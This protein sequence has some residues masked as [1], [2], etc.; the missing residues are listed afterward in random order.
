VLK[1]GEKITL[2]VDN[3]SG[4]LDTVVK[5]YDSNGNLVASSD[6]SSPS[7]G[8][9]GSSRDYWYLF[10]IPASYDSYL[11]YTATQDGA[12]YVDIE[13]KAGSGTYDLQVSIDN[14][15][16]F[17]GEAVTIPTDF[18]LANDSDLDG[19]ALS[20]V[21][22]SGA[23]VQLSGDS[24][25][26]Q[27]GV[28]SFSYTV[29]DGT[30]QQ[31]ATVS[32]SQIAGQTNTGTAADN[33]L[34][35]SNAADTLS[36]LG[37]HDLLFGGAG[38]DTLIGGTGSDTLRGGTGSDTFKWLSGDLSGG[39]IDTILDFETGPNGDVIDFSGLLAGVSGNKADHVRFVYSDGA[40]QLASANGTPHAAD[41]D[42]KIQVNLSGS[43][44]TD[45]ATIHDT[46]PN[47][48]AGD[49]VLKLLLDSSQLWVH[50]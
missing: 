17:Q 45:V 23:G 46:G 25:I 32:V 26:I 6:D 34:I 5:L 36:G 9:G 42:I 13:R 40:T 31:T 1:A 2:D 35:G 38:D 37:G 14:F 21:G 15:Q 48:T 12:Y 29:S 19:D 41:G 7:D 50:V 47:L 30:V 16:A 43:T 39:G 3:T 44:W 28:T 18:L 20:I 49:E 10:V 22:V 4:N 8:G 11:T 33:D 27:P 24:I